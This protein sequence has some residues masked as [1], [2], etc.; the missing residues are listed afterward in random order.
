MGFSKMR[1]RG[2]YAV[3]EVI[4]TILILMIATSAIAVITF[5]GVPYMNQQQAKGRVDSALAQFNAMNDI[6]KNDVIKQGFVGGNEGP[7][8]V[9]NFK[10]DSGEVSLNEKSERFVFYYSVDKDVDFDVFNLGDNNDNTFDFRDNNGLVRYL[11]IY[12]IADESGGSGISEGIPGPFPGG[13][14][15]RIPTT[16]ALENAVRINVYKE[17]PPLIVAGRIWLF[18]TGSILYKTFSGSD[19]YKLIAENSGII[20]ATNNNNYLSSKPDIIKD[21]VKR[22]FMMNMIQ[23]APSFFSGSGNAKYQITI[24]LIKY[25]A[26]NGIYGDALPGSK[27]FKM[28]VF[29]DG[30]MAWRNYFKIYQ[31]FTDIV[32]NADNTIES[33]GPWTFTLTQSICDLSMKVSQ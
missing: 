7:S 25:E 17:D 16:N 1:Y 20:S 9:V 28:Q 19:V 23:Y 31:G 22:I 5:W 4:G 30:E 24:K 14:P 33:V 13:N 10:T 21:D 15:I 32:G 29:G 3:S 27:S 26:L 18:D 11:K 6:I 12:L 8:A 2:N